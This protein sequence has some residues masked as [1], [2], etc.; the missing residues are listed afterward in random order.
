MIEPRGPG[1]LDTPPSRG[2]TISCSGRYPPVI[3]SEAKQSILSLCR[4]VD[5][6]ASLA[7]T[8][9]SRGVPDTPA[10]VAY[11]APLAP[12]KIRQTW[13]RDQGFTDA[14]HAHVKGCFPVQI[15][16]D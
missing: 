9:I 15:D 12:R 8:R 6:F 11:D 4:E 7:T 10:S 14:S 16:N 1:V 13:Q 3:A 5:C 2:K